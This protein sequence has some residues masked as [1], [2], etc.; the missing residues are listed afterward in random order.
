MFFSKLIGEKLIIRQDL[1]SPEGC[2][3][4]EEKPF[5][6]SFLERERGYPAKEKEFPIRNLTN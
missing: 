3:F 5:G 6:V 4:Q 1:W 2:F